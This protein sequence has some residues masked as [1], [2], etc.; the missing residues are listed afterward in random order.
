MTEDLTQYLAATEMV[1]ST[2]PEVIAYTQKVVGDATEPIEQAVRLYYAVRD[3]FLYNPYQVDLTVDALKTT[4]LLERG[5]GFCVEKANLMIAGAR[6][7]GIP[8]RF[9]F[10]DVRNHVGTSKLAEILQTNVLVFHGFVELYLKGEW[11]KA[12]PAFNKTLCEKLGVAALD[13]NG[14]DD[15]IFQENDGQGGKFMEYLY[16]H[17]TYADI[18]REY[19]VECLVKKYP[20]LFVETDDTDQ[21]VDSDHYFRV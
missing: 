12:T 10:A 7:L 13:F 18:P 9:G 11:V 5:S 6:H 2:H 20:H 19:M 21:A 3:D 15:S 1:E 17:G 4:A 8:A 16:D 14:R